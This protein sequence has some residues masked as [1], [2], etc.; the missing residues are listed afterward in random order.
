MKDHNY[1]D[2]NGNSIPVSQMNIEDIKDILSVGDLRIISE[3]DHSE[4]KE[5]ILERLRIEL[6]IRNGV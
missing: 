5:D 1:I 4:T 2:K 3:G 6:I